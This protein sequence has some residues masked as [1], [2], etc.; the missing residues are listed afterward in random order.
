MRWRLCRAHRESSIV[1]N[2][3]IS[4]SSYKTYLK[5]P[6]SFYNRTGELGMS[7]TGYQLGNY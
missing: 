2:I 6:T 1:L 5:G 7:Y 4:L 3:R